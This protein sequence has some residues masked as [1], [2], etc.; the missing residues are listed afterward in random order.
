M[1]TL[2]SAA[3]PKPSLRQIAAKA[4]VSVV[5]VSCALRGKPGVSTATRE[6]IR[7]IAESIGYRP[8]PLLSQ[9]MYHLR[10]RRRPRGRHNIAFLNWPGD[11]YR[12]QVLC[13]A[14][15]QAER[16]GYHMDVFRMGEDGPS[17]RVLNR[18][19]IA[20]GV[21]GLVISPSPVADY[22]E[23]LDWRKFSTVLTSHSEIGPNFHRVVP[24]QFS[25]IRLAVEELTKRG[26][27]RI[28][29]IVPPW[30]AEQSNSFH[31]VAFIC[32][33]SQHDATPLLCHFDPED[34][35]LYQ[36]REWYELNQPDALIL[37]GPL[38]YETVLCRAIENDA[39]ARLGIVS[40]GYET[41]SIDAL[42]VDYRPTTLGAIAVDQL[43][44]Q[45]HRGERGIPPVPQTLSVEGGLLHARS[46]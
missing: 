25:A 24:N 2:K 7:R 23:L 32:L 27:H 1:P 33:A 16:H 6:R 34:H 15:T 46:A 5:A 45:L 13:G 26:F 36:L 12:E 21:A 42:V 28:G 30:L 44:T 43:I 38:D 39:A 29:L 31:R 4:G 35:P 11:S 10:S 14:K 18:M 20:R 8:D 41:S 3:P 9:L 37:C 19:L 40:L 17:A 22:S